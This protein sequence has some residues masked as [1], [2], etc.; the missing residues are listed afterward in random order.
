MT[1]RYTVIKFHLDWTWKVWPCSCVSKS[2][3]MFYKTAWLIVSLENEISWHNVEL[4]C[5]PESSMRSCGDV[6]LAKIRCQNYLKIAVCSFE[7][8]TVTLSLCKYVFLNYWTLNAF[9]TYKAK[10]FLELNPSAL[11]VKHSQHIRNIEVLMSELQKLCMFNVYGQT[12]LTEYSQ[13]NHSDRLL[14][15]HRVEYDR[16]CTYSSLWLK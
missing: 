11:N 1:D 12:L 4:I 13:F 8:K 2:Y 5:N 6:I 16:D 7:L 14:Y 15:I 10:V 9:S 3:F